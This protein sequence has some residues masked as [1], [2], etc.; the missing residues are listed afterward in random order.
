MP[1]VRS[2]SAIVRP[3]QEMLA[4]PTEKG[5]FFNKIKPEFDNLTRDYLTFMSHGLFIF[6]LNI[7]FRDIDTFGSMCAREIQ[8]DLK[9]SDFFYKSYSLYQIGSK[10]GISMN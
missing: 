7:F 3:N 10:I 9:N 6:L 8:F 4:G 2:Q 1:I 5:Y